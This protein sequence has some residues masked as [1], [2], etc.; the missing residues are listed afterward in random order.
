MQDIYAMHQQ[1]VCALIFHDHTRH[2][3]LFC[4]RKKLNAFTRV[5][6][7]FLFAQA[8][9]DSIAHTILQSIRY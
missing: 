3:N 1:T 7:S 9:K 5:N 4:L 8:S 6:H 2:Y